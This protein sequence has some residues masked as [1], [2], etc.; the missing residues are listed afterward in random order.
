MEQGTSKPKV[1]PKDFFL[2][3]GAMATLYGSAIALLTLLFNYIDRWLPDAL[4]YGDFSSSG[5]RL[6]V[7]ALVVVFPLYVF[8][9]S[10][11][12]KDLRAHPEKRELWVRRWLVYATLFIGGLVLVIDLVAVINVYLQGELSTRFALKCLAIFA[13]VGGGF[14]Y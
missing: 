3:L 4:S 13:V 1:T 8:L 5:L 7:S 9:T 2:W 14:L 6:A 10:V 11:L 12:H